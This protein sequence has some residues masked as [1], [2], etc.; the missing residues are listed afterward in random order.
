MAVVVDAFRDGGASDAGTPTART[1]AAADAL[2][3]AGIGGTLVYT[4]PDCRLHAVRLPSLEPAAVPEWRGSDCWFELSPDGARLAPVRARWHASREYAVCAG[5]YVEV[6]ASPDSLPTAVQRGCA[7]AWRPRVPPALTLARN[8]EIIELH[9][10]CEREPS[11]GRVVIGAGAIL[12]AARQHPNVPDV[13]GGIEAIEIEDHVWLS[14]L[15]VALLL[16]VRI[17]RVGPQDLV[18]VFEGGRVRGSYYF[19]D[20]DRDRLEASPGGRYVAS[21]TGFAVRADGPRLAVPDAFGEVRALAWSPDERWLA[22]AARGTVAFV[23]AG[24]DPQPRI[25]TVP[26][27]AL[28][29]G[30]APR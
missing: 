29:L 10:A 30:W 14:P 8:G 21:G 12:S 17:D 2:R 25:V 24:V 1:D 23:E 9:A 13:P 11:C 26:L 6:R 28:D 15:R 20:D 5:P 27:E 22:L 18:A 4:D 19:F 7:P 3:E 16:R